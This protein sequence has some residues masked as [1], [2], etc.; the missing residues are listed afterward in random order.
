MPYTLL[1]SEK[2][3]H[4]Y[5]GILS[6][7]CGGIVISVIGQP[8][9]NIKFRL[10]TQSHNEYKGM[11]D[12]FKV[13]LKNEGIANL[14]K[15]LSLTL[16]NQSIFRSTLF[17]TQGET[18]KLLSDRDNKN[19]IW[20]YFV[21]GSIGWGLGSIL[22]CPT[23]VIRLQMQKLIMEN[24]NSNIKSCSQ[25]MMKNGGI[26]CFYLGYQSHLLRNTLAGGIH[27]GTYDIMREYTANYKNINVKDIKLHENLFFG[28]LSGVLFWSAIYPLD[29]IKSFL[30]SD[31]IKNKQ[32]NGI[33]DC[34]NKLYKTGG[35][36]TFYKGL[37]PCLIRAIP[38]NALMLYVVTI[39]NEKF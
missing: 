14:F 6:G 20:H 27:L 8:F 12:C 16:F 35:I 9:D 10:Q 25:F 17:L 3:N 38:A 19:K 1:F 31:N 22:E 29:V 28:A 39:I 7:A 5:K 24:H 18:K 15:G 26:K 33:F 36:G 13:M 21:A 23:D 30:Q 32:Y 37:T 34:A 4:T 2:Y 11:F